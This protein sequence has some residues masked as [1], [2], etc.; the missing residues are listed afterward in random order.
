MIDTHCH[1]L[2]ALDDGPRTLADSVG[3]AGELAAAGVRRVVCTPHYSRRY[4]TD[5]AV[6]RERLDELEQQLAR[7]DVPVALSLGA[8]LSSAFAVSD[9]MSE[10]V[11]RTIE[12]RFLLVELEPAT[13]A[14]VLETVVERLEGQGLRPI[15]AHPE[16]S[17][18]VR[19]QPRLLAEARAAGALVQVVSPSLV[20]RWG[21][22]V[23]T[24]AWRLL[25]RGVVDLLA[26]DSHRRG[27]GA[28]SLARALDAI[29]RRYGAGV[30]AE[31][32]EHAPARIV[33][34]GAAES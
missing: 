22:E 30:V 21:G 3:L 28:V 5:P 31:L 11:R 32:T 2:H 29:D 15:F 16:R 20:G 14:A 18:S 4:P 26:S 27:R 10:L 8:E 23:E 33:T 9:P 25:D 6:A 34:V 17:K 7:S 1:L 19:E 12:G 24:A 13:P